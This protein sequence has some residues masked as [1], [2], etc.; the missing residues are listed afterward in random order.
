M[1]NMDILEQKIRLQKLIN[2]LSELGEDPEELAFWQN[3][4]EA[5]SEEERE[6]LFSNLEEEKKKL[7]SLKK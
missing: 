6:K 3:F 4:L 2:D 5:M 1:N 7:E